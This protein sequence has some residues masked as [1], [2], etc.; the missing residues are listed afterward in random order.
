MS[1]WWKNQPVYP[2]LFNLQLKCRNL[3]IWIRGT[4]KLHY[5]DNIFYLNARRTLLI[6]TVGNHNAMKNQ[7]ILAPQSPWL[8][9]I[10]D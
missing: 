7:I 6:G 5:L 8:C 1:E 2:K 4:F 3:E 9:K 10:K